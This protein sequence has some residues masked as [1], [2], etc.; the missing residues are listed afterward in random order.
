MKVLL[1]GQHR[2]GDRPRAGARGEPAG[3]DRRGRRPEAASGCGGRGRLS[4]D[5]TFSRPA[6]GALMC[7]QGRGLVGRWLVDVREE[8]RE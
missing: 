6:P 5:R 7:P 4:G 2:R 1:W 8:G 3:G